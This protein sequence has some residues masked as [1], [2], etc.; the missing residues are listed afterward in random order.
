MSCQNSLNQLVESEL[1]VEG[2]TAKIS[3]NS[4]A[5]KGNSVPAQ[6]AGRQ[7]RIKEHIKL[8]KDSNRV[9]NLASREDAQAE[10]SKFLPSMSS[11]RKDDRAGH[12]AKRAMFI[13]DALGGQQA[14]NA[15]LGAASFNKI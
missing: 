1:S 9:S 8:A 10:R 7:A 4:F 6:T 15:D 12:D 5:K 11:T 13:D 3:S 2:A 14:A